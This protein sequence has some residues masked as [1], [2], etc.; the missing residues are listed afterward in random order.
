MS[1]FHSK[2]YRYP[3][4]PLVKNTTA[5]VL[6][7]FLGIGTAA[8][9]VGYFR[10]VGLAPI[11]Y[12]VL[13][14]QL[15]ILPKWQ[16]VIRPQADALMVGSSFHL[17]STFDQ[18][19]IERTGSERNLRLISSE[20]KVH[21]VVIRDDIPGFDELAQACFFHINQKPKSC[22]TNFSAPEDQHA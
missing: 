15:R 3:R 11:F 4:W 5:C 18:L 9:P 12:G 17:W 21:D 7:V 14:W 13:R 8:A 2:S 19:Q 1:W 16:Y 22:E 10:W 20:G 6:W